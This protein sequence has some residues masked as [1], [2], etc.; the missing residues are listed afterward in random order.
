MDNLTLL[1]HIY[2][3]P[4][5]CPFCDSENIFLTQGPLTDDLTKQ[6]I[7][8]ECD[9]GKEWKIITGIISVEEIK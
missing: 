9:C 7:I 6:T 4:N 2:D 5:T 1:R 3:N 8:F